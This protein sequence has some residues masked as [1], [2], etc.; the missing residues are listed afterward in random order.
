MF[1]LFCSGEKERRQQITKQKIYAKVYFND[2]EVCTSTVRQLNSDF[3]V[4]F[5][6]VYNLHV[7]EWPQSITIK[8]T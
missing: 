8:V 2:L 5:G 7:Y 3:C 6:H 1:S 4:T